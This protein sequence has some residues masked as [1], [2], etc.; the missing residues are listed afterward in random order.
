MWPGTVPGAQNT[1][2]N[3]TKKDSCPQGAGSSA[4]RDRQNKHN[5]KRVRYIVFRK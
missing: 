2:V 3:Q 1:F 4:G 5:S